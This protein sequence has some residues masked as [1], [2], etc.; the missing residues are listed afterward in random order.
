MTAQAT[1]PRVPVETRAP[2]ALWKERIGK[3]TSLPEF[4]ASSSPNQ[5]LAVNP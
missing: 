4:P 3:E 2:P 5:L 1:F